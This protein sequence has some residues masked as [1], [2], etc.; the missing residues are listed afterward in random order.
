M[1]SFL[2]A[3]E[4]DYNQEVIY[5][6]YLICV[7]D[8]LD[9]YLNGIPFPSDCLGFWID[10]G[11]TGSTWQPNLHCNQYYE[12]NTLLSLCYWEGAVPTIPNAK[13][14]CPK[15]ENVPLYCQY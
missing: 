3:D 1:I 2:A 13:C 5:S 6:P 9:D 14:S 4:R 10:L 12:N 11:S 7:W 8:H 15:C